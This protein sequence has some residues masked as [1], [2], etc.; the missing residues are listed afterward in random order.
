MWWRTLVTLAEAEIGAS[1]ELTG[2][3][4]LIGKP[5]LTIKG[6]EQHSIPKDDTRVYTKNTQAYAHT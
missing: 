5:Q 3:Y 4:S 2:H 6:G 1:Q